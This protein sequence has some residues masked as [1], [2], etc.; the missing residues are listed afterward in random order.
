MVTMT[1]S[2]QTFVIKSSLASINLETI[3]NSITLT[4]HIIGAK[5]K[6]STIGVVNVS[7]RKQG[8]RSF[9]NCL[10]LTLLDDKRLNAKIFRNGSI[11]LTGCREDRHAD[12]CADII[13]SLVSENTGAFEFKTGE[14]EI[15]Y[16]PMSVMENINFSLGFRLDREKLGSI[17]ANS[18][19]YFIPPLTTG[20]MGVKIK[21]PIEDPGST[22]KIPRVVWKTGERTIMKYNEYFAD[23]KK[24]LSKKF[25]TSVNIFQNG[26]VLISGVN[27]SIIT[28]AVCWVRNMASSKRDL[29]EIKERKVK[30]FNH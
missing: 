6:A 7:K 23:D 8:P 24:K 9:L 19:E 22:I 10:T 15:I 18:S 1:V 11:Q 14:T 29:V 13:Y 16:Y 20:Y 12:F 30:T 28:P 3:Y 17:I 2:T 5:Y 4:D 26:K 25:L 27:L 21:I